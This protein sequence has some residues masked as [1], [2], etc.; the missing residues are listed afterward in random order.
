VTARRLSSVGR[1]FLERVP[2]QRALERAAANAIEQHRRAGLPLVIW[3]NGKIASV[4]AD[5]VAPSPALRS[6]RR[7]RKP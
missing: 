7:L 3:R 6:K 2:I 5:D 4:F 1:A